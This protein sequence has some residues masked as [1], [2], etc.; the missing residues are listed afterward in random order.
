VYEYEYVDPVPLARMKGFLTRLGDV[1]PLLSTDDDQL[2][3]VGPGDEARLEFE[4]KELPELPAGWT[5]SYVLK[6][7]GYCKDADP[8]TLGSDSVSPLPWRTMPAFPFPTH[9]ERP[10]DADYARYL[11]EYQ[12]RPAGVR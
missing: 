11:R 4:A 6:A 7:I 5:R 10:V 8:F 9:L 2:C 1:T 12:T 3:T